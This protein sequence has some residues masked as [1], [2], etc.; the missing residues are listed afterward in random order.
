MLQYHFFQTDYEGKFLHGLSFILPDDAAA[1]AKARE[2][3]DRCNV[4]IWQG[5]KKVSVIRGDHKAA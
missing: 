5:Q 4:E 3:A 2:L 1:V